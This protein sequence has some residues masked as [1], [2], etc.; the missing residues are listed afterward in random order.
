MDLLYKMLDEQLQLIIMPTEKCNFNC[1]YCYENF[2]HG[3]RS[4]QL[5]NN[6]KSF[7]IEQLA[8][9]PFKSVYISWFG[10]E[11]TLCKDIVLDLNHAIKDMCLKKD[12]MFDSSMTTNGY[13]LDA[14]AVTEFYNSGISVYQITIDGFNHDKNRSLRGGGK[15]LDTLLNNLRMIRELPHDLNFQIIVRYNIQKDGEDLAWYDTLQ[16]IFDGDNRFSVLVKTV[17][18]FG[19]DKVK[20]LEILNDNDALRVIDQHIDYAKRIELN[21]ENEALKTPLSS[22]CYA[23]LKNSYIFR[24]NGEIVKCSLGLDEDDNRVGCVKGDVCINEAKN[25]KW[26]MSRI[27]DDCL[28]CFDILSCLNQKCP[29]SLN[30]GEVCVKWGA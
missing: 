12:I 22:V 11:P 2:K 3:K 13:L 21:I 24:A 30:K 17:G 23:S 8:I 5:V 14:S 25:K 9:N 6:I 7:I 15:T 26:Y 27:T 4:Q 16:D 1:S 10:G 19:G 18:D 20:E 29:K 28:Q